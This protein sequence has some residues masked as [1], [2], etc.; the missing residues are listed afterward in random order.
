VRDVEHAL[1]EA[2][3]PE[4]TLSRSTVSRICQAI[5]DEFDA[6]KT[7]DLSGIT[8]DDLFCDASMFR[9]H[10]GS[11][12]EPVLCS[13]GIT[14]DGAKVLVGL[15]EGAA[16]SYEAWLEAFRDL[17]ARGLQPPLLGITDGAPGL[18][19]AFEE[20]FDPSLRQRWVVHKARNV[21]AKV[22]RAD[23]E[24]VKAASWSIFDAIEQ[25]PGQ[26]A[27]NEA[28]RR[29]QAFAR[30]YERDYPAAVACLMK[31]LP[32]LTTFLRF[33][34]EHWLRVRHTNPLER[35]FGETRRGVKVIGR[36][37]G[38]RSCMS[39]VWAVLDRS[40]HGWRGLTQTPQ[41][42][43]LLQDLRRQLLVDEQP[44]EVIEET[45]TT[46]A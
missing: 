11:R 7:R 36:L 38:E 2:L 8:L 20:A 41:G 5:K 42:L 23:Q 12:A 10:Q 46:A 25:Q 17:K 6:W 39:L 33:P 26:A 22:P 37:P 43:R 14:T 19:Q 4:A 34:R 32:E 16:E 31:D 18:V 9:M 13:W 1:A 35:T 24:E 30:R 28:R 21:L 27:V 40:S 15:H 44:R 3:G 45:V 29:A